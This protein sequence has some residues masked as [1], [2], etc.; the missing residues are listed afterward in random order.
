MTD[1][2]IYLKAAEHIANVENGP[3]CIAIS[4]SSGG[5]GG[6]WFCRARKKYSFMFEFNF[7]YKTPLTTNGKGVRRTPNQEKRNLR[8]ML[9]CMAAAVEKAG[10]L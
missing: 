6:M 5:D 8:V 10:G 2:E 7:L 1:Y 3:S 9:L 4:R